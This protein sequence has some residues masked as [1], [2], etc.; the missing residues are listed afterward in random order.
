MAAYKWFAGKASQLLARVL[1]WAWRA[2]R[3]TPSALM[4]RISSWKQ[5]DQVI[6]E[7]Y[8][9]S[10]LFRGEGRPRDSQAARKLINLKGKPERE[11]A[12]EVVDPEAVDTQG[13]PEVGEGSLQYF[14]DGSKFGG[15]PL[16]PKGGRTLLTNHT[17]CGVIEVDPNGRT[18]RTQMLKLP[19]WATVYQSELTGI[20]AACK[21]ARI[22]INSEEGLR[23]WNG[24]VEIC[25][26]NMT[27]LKAAGGQLN[28]EASKAKEARLEVRQ[29]KEV[30]GS[31][32]GEVKLRWVK[33]HRGHLQNAQADW[34]A[35]MGGLRGTAETCPV[36]WA[37]AKE[38]LT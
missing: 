17:G 28:K 26:D 27:A 5:L 14:T 8:V 15:V 25:A 31:I 33:A 10:N 24:K 1:R 36:S 2:L 32:G 13:S 6:I 20:I 18:R 38:M 7:R 21:L 16:R 9:R 37:H 4:I 29:L 3:S 34:L 19:S 23:G 30:I 12:R 11:V 35:K 22:R